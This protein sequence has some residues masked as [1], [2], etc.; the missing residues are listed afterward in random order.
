M[1]KK[2]K[3]G[4]GLGR[5]FAGPDESARMPSERSRSNAEPGADADE[6]ET[7]KAILAKY[8]KY[9]AEDGVPFKGSNP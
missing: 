1:K 3:W 6:L 7:P 8:G 4:K 5:L 2:G 9:R